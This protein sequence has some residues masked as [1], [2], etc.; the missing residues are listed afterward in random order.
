MESPRG[1]EIPLS[2]RHDGISSLPF[3]NPRAA[4][5]LQD[6]EITLSSQELPWQRR[7]VLRKLKQVLRKPTSKHPPKSLL[8]CSRQ[9]LQCIPVNLVFSCPRK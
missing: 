6:L 7:N 4:A 8:L 3:N 5:F 1:E 9:K 2:A